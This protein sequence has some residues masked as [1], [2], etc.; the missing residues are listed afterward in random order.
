MAITP[1]VENVE[2]FMRVKLAASREASLPVTD[3]TVHPFVTI[4]RQSGAGGHALAETM[5]EVFGRQDGDELFGE[6]QVFDQRLC[7]VVAEDQRL[8]GALDS[9]LSEEYRSRSEEFFHQLLQPTTDQSY[10]MDRV[11]HTVR[12]LAGIGKVIIV[13][14]AG[15]EVTRDMHHGLSL[16]LIAPEK[17]RIERLMELHGLDERPARDQARKRD[18]SRA[19]LLKR[20]F[21]VDIDDPLGYDA[22]FNT[23]AVPLESIAEAVAAMVRNRVGVGAS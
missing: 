19:R 10:L 23:A 15:S 12:M 4:S 8:A 5:V 14:R 21:K 22:T 18:A 2:R 3:A 11:F 7:E 9:L 20:Y 1:S 6:W 13:G 16:R 17:L